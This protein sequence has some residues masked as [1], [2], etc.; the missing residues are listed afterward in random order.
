MLRSLLP[1][2]ALSLAACHLALGLDDYTKGAAVSAA[3]TSSTGGSG[4]AGQGGA[5]QGGAGGAGQGGGASAVVWA[6]EFGTPTPSFKSRPNP[7]LSFANG[8]IGIAARLD[9]PGEAF[10]DQTLPTSN[11]AALT[12]VSLTDVASP[13]VAALWQAPAE[14][15]QLPVNLFATAATETGIWYAAVKPTSELDYVILFFHSKTGA[16]PVATQEVTTMSPI[17][18]FS[19]S[20]YAPKSGNGRVDVAFSY[21]NG[22][23]KTTN[24]LRLALVD[25]TFLNSSSPENLGATA[26]QGDSVVALVSTANATYLATTH[27]PSG[28]GNPSAR[29][30]VRS[31]ADPAPL[32]TQGAI[33][34]NAD[35]PTRPTRPLGLVA[36]S[37]H[38]YLALESECDAL[39]LPGEPAM[40]DPDPSNSLTGPPKTFTVLSFALKSNDSL[41]GLFD[42]TASHTAPFRRSA[43]SGIALTTLSN[44]DSMT[45]RVV[46]AG[47]VNKDLASVSSGGTEEVIVKAEGD[48]QNNAFVLSLAPDLTVVK[49][50]S[51]LTNGTETETATSIAADGTSVLLA[52][53]F[54]G[55]LTLGGKTFTA[56]SAKTRGFVTRLGVANL[57]GGL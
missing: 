50:G 14:G 54:T 15:A 13:V 45:S 52:G 20:A 55:A 11:P 32:V 8:R 19:I 53:T 49:S 16:A 1:F 17:E 3:S 41:N 9:G 37:N 56:P 44:A 2:A 12:L 23:T 33:G 40:Y 34:C 7:I 22:A 48:M 36:G 28:G 46:L 5:G 43:G 10:F 4:G 6:S 57:G 31:A 51:A 18:G 29:V 25:G 24:L 26:Q 35:P 39:P 21:G 27:T 47:T 42:E 30:Y 38:L